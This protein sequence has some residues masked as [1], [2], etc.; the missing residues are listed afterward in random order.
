MG[1]KDRLRFNMFRKRASDRENKTNMIQLFKISGIFLTVIL[2]TISTVLVLSYGYN[3]YRSNMDSKAEAIKEEQNA[4]TIIDNNK[5]EQ[6][7]NSEEIP[8]INE[9]DKVFNIT[10]LGEIMMG[11]NSFRIENN[12]YMLAFKN[13]VE[14]TKAADYTICNLTTNISNLDEIEDAKSKYVVP[15][16]IINAFNAL[17]VDGVNIANDHAL[18]FGL[19]QFNTTLSILRDNDINVIG[20]SKD[21]V[22]AESSG[23]RVAFIA[24]NNVPIGIRNNYISAGINMYDRTKTKALIVEAKKHADTVI[25]M[26]H[27]G[28]E[29]T[30]IVTYAMKEVAKGLI[31]SGADMVIGSHAL[32]IHPPEEYKGKIIIYSA[33]YL[34]HDT[35]YEIGKKSAIFNID[36]DIKGQITK[37]ELLPVYIEDE[38]EVKLYSDIDKKASDEYL[39]KLM[40][41][42]TFD[43]YGIEKKQGKL[44]MTLKSK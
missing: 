13:V 40:V 30:Y 28:K 22:Y 32:G 6:A 18:D 26:P 20:L 39:K 17:G 15:K 25:A 29:N 36:I 16:P 5:L 12:S 37:A 42:K 8:V 11:G 10:V 23:I 7:Q 44:V 34:M 35:Y 43:K 9:I 4:K 2:V 24:I 1:I 14:Y 3:Q 33:G 19:I 41:N 21:I 31:D 27:Y 38:K